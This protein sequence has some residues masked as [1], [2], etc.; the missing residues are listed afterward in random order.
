MISVAALMK[1]ATVLVTVSGLT[2][3]VEDKM[4]VTRY[5]AAVEE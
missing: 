5:Y 1:A 4:G 2:I 3:G